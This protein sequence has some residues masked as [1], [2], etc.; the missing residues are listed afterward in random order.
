MS[1]LTY[2]PMF[3]NVKWPKG[4]AMKR[5]ATY[6]L[7]ALLA[8]APMVATQ[9]ADAQQ[10]DPPRNNFYGTNPEYLIFGL[11]GAGVIAAAIIL[12]ME[13]H[14]HHQPPPQVSP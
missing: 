2:K 11:A 4:W 3:S 8:A 13:N 6:G 1:P 5:I 9:P 10:A 12:A 14:E 7:V